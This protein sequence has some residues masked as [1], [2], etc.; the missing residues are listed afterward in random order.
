LPLNAFVT[1]VGLGA[2]CGRTGD[3]PVEWFSWTSDK[4]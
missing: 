1:L 4:P 3:R 2:F